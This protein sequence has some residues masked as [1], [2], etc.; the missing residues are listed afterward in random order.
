MRVLDNSTSYSE[1]GEKARQGYLLAFEGN[2]R[3]TEQ[4]VSIKAALA[5]WAAP[6]ESSYKCVA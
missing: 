6:E 3:H 4:K 2:G 1:D 5:S